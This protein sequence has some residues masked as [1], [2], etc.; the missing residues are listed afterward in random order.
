MSDNSKVDSNSSISQVVNW[1]EVLNQVGGDTA[2]LFEVLDDLLTE[3]ETAQTEIEEGIRDAQ[4]DKIM[5]SAHRIKGSASYMC[6]EALKSVAYDLQYAGL[7]G[8]NA[9]SS[10]AIGIWSRINDLFATYKDRFSELKDEIV[11]R[12][13]S[14]GI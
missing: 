7:A 8:T 11:A 4:F 10:D 6:C 9:T 14:A 13:A 5:K 3:A 12:R 2:F 1:E